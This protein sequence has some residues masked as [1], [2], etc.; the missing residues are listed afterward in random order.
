MLCI[1]S[2]FCY[3]PTAE[4]KQDEEKQEVEEKA[5]EERWVMDNMVFSLGLSI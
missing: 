4:Q 5:E 3:I 1:L 2:D